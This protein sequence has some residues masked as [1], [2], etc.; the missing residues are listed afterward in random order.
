MGDGGQ[1]GAK[2]KLLSP[3]V[4]V[5]S[6]LNTPGHQ[7]LFIKSSFKESFIVLD[8]ANKQSLTSP[9]PSTTE[10][11]DE[12]SALNTPM[13]ARLGFFSQLWVFIRREFVLQ[14]RMSRTLLLDQ[15]LTMIAGAVLG[16]LFREVRM[17]WL[18]T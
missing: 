5:W 10:D 8:N 16:L 2:S 12:Q 13:I 18:L 4:L 9:V 7:L 3:L 14:L 11:V 17:S 1:T 6:R 15:A